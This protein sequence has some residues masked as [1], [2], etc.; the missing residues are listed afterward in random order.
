MLYSKIVAV[1]PARNEEKTLPA[2]LQALL[3]QKYPLE[4]IIVVNDGSSDKTKEV[5]LTYDKV[6][7]TD[8]EYRGVDAVGKALLAE[9]LNAGFQK[10]AELVHDYDFVLVVDADT[11]LPNNYLK[12]LMIEFDAN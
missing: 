11:I 10:V 7:V 2:T 8:K 5:A 4:K 6:V 1:V 9:T 12:Q 3:H